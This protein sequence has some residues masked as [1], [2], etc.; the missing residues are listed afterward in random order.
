[1]FGLSKF[2]DR[3]GET[4]WAHSACTRALHAGLPAELRTQAT[5]D[6]A[7]MAKRRGEYARAAALWEELAAHSQD[8]ALACEQLAIY[9]E[10]HMRDLPRA[11][12]FTELALKKLQCQIAR[13]RDPFASSRGMHRGRELM[14][15]LKRLRHR[16][17]KAK[18][19]AG[20]PLLAHCEGAASGSRQRLR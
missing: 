16:N 20:A 14:C 8:G 4:D 15:R 6:L 19:G 9:Y 13:S 1:L 11:I 2:L 5:R 7:L 17:H 3:K 18:A 12:E 10:R